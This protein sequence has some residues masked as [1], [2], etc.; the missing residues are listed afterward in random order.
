MISNNK[1]S[2]RAS[3]FFYACAITVGIYISI[4]ELHFFG[5]TY[6]FIIFGIATLFIYIIELFTAFQSRNRKIQIN[7]NFN[8]EVNELS[9]VFHKVIL[10]VLLYIGLLG[11]SYYN[12]TSGS[13][14]L[15]LI[16][17][18]FSFYL[19]ILNTKLF[20]DHDVKDEQST[21]YVYDIIK[22]LIFFLAIDT[23]S[24]SFI[25]S[26]ENLVLYTFL[27]FG[28]SLLISYLMILRIKKGSF[29]SFALSLIFSLFISGGFWLVSS[30]SKFNP[31]Q[32]SLILIFLFYITT[33]IIHHRIRNTLTKEILLEYFLVS[34]LL[35]S[36][37]FLGL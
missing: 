22:F 26:G 37:A 5:N 21:H 13:L 17:T 19:L 6:N 8:D 10:P 28:V 16:I 24:N 4:N 35:L 27:V 18:L 14:Y 1:I 15:V 32:I 9:E 7:L 31:L 30:F 20:L 23:F 12:I 2:R 36:I 3:S 29:K 11:F 25:S 34:I 33:A